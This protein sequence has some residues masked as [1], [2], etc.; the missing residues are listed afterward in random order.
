MLNKTVL[1]ELCRLVN[2][3][4]DYC[5][6]KLY[7]NFYMCF[8]K[9]G[10]F[11]DD[12]I[13]KFNVMKEKYANHNNNEHEDK[14][15][16]HAIIA[17]VDEFSFQECCTLLSFVLRAERWSEGWFEECLRNGSIQSLLARTQEIINNNI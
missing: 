4:S 11:D 14:D 6:R 2:G 12:Y 7:R 8:V 10:C 5:D 1:D 3:A 13:N 17:H 15:I 16:C 9:T